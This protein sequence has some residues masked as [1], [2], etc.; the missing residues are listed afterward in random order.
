MPWKNKELELK[1]EHFVSKLQPGQ[2]ETWTLV[3][4]PKSK[5]QSRNPVPEKAVAE[6]VA[7]LYDESLD[8]FAPLDWPHRF[9]VFREDYSTMQSQFANPP[10]GFQQVFG[11]WDRP[12]EGVEITYRSFPPDLTVNLWGYGYFPGAW[13]KG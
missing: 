11:G 7:T 12:Y 13:L 3:R 2:K 5:V 10:M 9:S 8:A 1:W 4:S 6:M